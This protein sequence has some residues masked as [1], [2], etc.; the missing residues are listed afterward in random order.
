VATVAAG[1]AGADEFSEPVL[2]TAVTDVDDSVV[3]L[4]AAGGAAL[5]LVV[6]DGANCMKF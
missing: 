5:V 1:T 2:T 3:S 4:D 6:A